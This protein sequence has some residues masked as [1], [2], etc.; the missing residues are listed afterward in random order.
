MPRGKTPASN[1][2][3]KQVDKCSMK[4]IVLLRLALLFSITVTGILIAR[5]SQR[6]ALAQTH[7]R[8]YRMDQRNTRFVPQRLVIP[9]GATV[10]FENHDVSEHNVTLDLPEGNQT[11]HKDMGTFPPGRRFPTPSTRPGEIRVHGKIHPEM[12][13][14]IMVR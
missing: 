9:R 8:K 1:V 7:T 5:G 11:L 13:A 2:H 10:T 6:S 3:H 12:T 14:T 4:T